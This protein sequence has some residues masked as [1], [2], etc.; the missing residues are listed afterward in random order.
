MVKA[1]AE[2]LR[3]FMPFLIL[4]YTNDVEQSIYLLSFQ[5]STKYP[6]ICKVFT[7]TNMILSPAFSRKT[8]T[9][10]NSHKRKMA[11]TVD[12]LVLFL[13]VSTLQHTSS[14]LLFTKEVFIRKRSC[15]KVMFLHLSVSHSVHR[16]VSAP[17][18]A[19][20]HTPPGQTPPWQTPPGRHLP[21]QTPQGKHPPWSDTLQGRHPPPH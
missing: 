19:G 4:V 18:H 11:R 16:G 12:C 9:K 17:V 6:S 8:T 20:I 2:N 15:G 5:L 3:R 21:G 13:I 7:L 10:L 14:A 1:S